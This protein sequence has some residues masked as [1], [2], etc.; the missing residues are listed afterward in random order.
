MNSS[1]AH[2]QIFPAPFGAVAARYDETFTA[3]SIGRAQRAA[4]WN[5][6]KKNFRAGDRILEIG[7]GTGVDACFLAER[8]VEVLACDPSSQMIEVTERR[9][10][11]S[12]LEGLV[13]TRV[14]YAEEISTL[15][16][17]L[18]DGA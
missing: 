7:C 5:E 13:R 1:A 4:V 3:S 14:L 15:S 10:R 12:G 8:G 11:Q 17:E 2:P 9:V 16:G 6:L 18:F